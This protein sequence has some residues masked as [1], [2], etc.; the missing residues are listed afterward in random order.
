VF[1]AGSIA[2]ALLAARI[3]APQPRFLLAAALVFG[4]LE[5]FAALSSS[6]C[7]FVLLLPAVGLSGLVFTTAAATSMQLAA[8]PPVRGR[9]AGIFTLVFVGG[10]PLGGVLAGTVTDTYGPR[11]ALATAGTAIIVAA[12]TVG[13]IA[14]RRRP[15]GLG[16]DPRLPKPHIA[17]SRA[18]AEK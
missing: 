16:K 2:G 17:R 5:V 10:N 15:S 12:V 1:A 8:D 11:I 18:G 13:L 14:T 6:L 3:G 9:V 7:F 4:L